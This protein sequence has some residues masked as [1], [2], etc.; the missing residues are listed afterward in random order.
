MFRQIRAVS[1]GIV[2]NL[3]IYRKRPQFGGMF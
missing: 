3:I 1:S 2:L